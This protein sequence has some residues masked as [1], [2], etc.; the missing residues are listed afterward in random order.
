MINVKTAHSDNYWTEGFEVSTPDPD[1]VHV[2]AGKFLSDKGD[3]FI[4][5]SCEEFAFDVVGDP[6]FQVVYDAFLLSDGTPYVQRTEWAG[7]NIPAYTG[8]VPITYTILTLIMPPG[9][10]DLSDV[11]ITAFQ[12]VKQD[13]ENTGA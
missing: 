4:E 12:A 2:A 6:D 10:A 9:A 3:K 8:E 7:D 1:S 13:E 11:T 5:V